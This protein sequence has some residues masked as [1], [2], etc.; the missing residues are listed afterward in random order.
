MEKSGTQ[1]M[2]I[3]SVGQDKKGFFYDYPIKITLEE[4]NLE[5]TVSHDQFARLFGKAR[6]LFGL[7]R[8]PS[9]IDMGRNYI[10]HTYESHYKFR[11]NF[12]FGD[13]MITRIRVLSVK[14]SSFELGAEFINAQTGENH[15][16]GKQIIACTKHNG[17]PIRIPD[18]LRKAL[19]DTQKT[20]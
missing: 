15:V 3:G 17:N 20:T 19:V 9:L 11:K 7:E 10:L 16:T 1:M 2:P 12:Y 4:T 8:L 18:D 14:N 5:G 6:E 13:T